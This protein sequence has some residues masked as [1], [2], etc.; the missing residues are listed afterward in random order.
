[1]LY[2]VYLFIEDRDSS[3]SVVTMLR[4]VWPGNRARLLADTISTAS[5]PATRSTHLPSQCIGVRQPEREPKYPP[6]SMLQFKTLGGIPTSHRPREDPRE[7]V[8][9]ASGAMRG[10]AGYRSEYWTATD[11]STSVRRLRRSRNS[12]GLQ[13]TSALCGCSH[14]G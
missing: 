13:W 11:C 1:M 4:D 12:S 9:L 10:P 14:I 3:V 2:T 7:V 5:R 8:V 6:S